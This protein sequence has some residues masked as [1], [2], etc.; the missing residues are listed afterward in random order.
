[1]NEGFIADKTEF[2]WLGTRAGGWQFGEQGI[3]VPEMA[4]HCH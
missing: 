2:E 4:N 1:M 3:L